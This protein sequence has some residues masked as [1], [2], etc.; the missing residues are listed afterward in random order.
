M[1]N[2]IMT[3]GLLALGGGVGSILRAVLSGQVARF[4]HPSVGIFVV[5][6]SGSFLI[7]CAWSMFVMTSDLQ[8][9]GIDDL[10]FQLFAVGM[11]GGYTT[12]SSFALQSLEL[13]QTGRRKAAILN[14]FGSVILCPIAAYIGAAMLLSGGAS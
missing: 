8:G 2:A 12:V 11:L 10:Y 5:N 7:G 6:L 4:A 3:L 13:W 1:I 9:R 14:S